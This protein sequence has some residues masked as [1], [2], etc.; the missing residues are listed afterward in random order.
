MGTTLQIR[1]LIKHFEVKQLGTFLEIFGIYWI[2]AFV[3]QETI[4][5]WRKNTQNMQKVLKNG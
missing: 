2:I 4:R 1:A 5:K 3:Y